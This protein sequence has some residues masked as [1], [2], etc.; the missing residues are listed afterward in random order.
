M[1]TPNSHVVGRAILHCG[2]HRRGARATTSGQRIN[3]LLLCRSSVFR[4]L[5][6]YRT[7]LSG[8]CVMCKSEKEEKR[9]QAIS[10]FKMV[11]R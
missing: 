4:D 10:A 11:L 3:M 6:K 1:H 7:D 5:S 9:R 2:R 8:W